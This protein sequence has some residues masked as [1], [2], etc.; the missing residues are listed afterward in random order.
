MGDKK[1]KGRESRNT[2]RWG[3][4]RNKEKGREKKQERDKRWKRG[5]KKKMEMEKVL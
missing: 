2:E 4:K 5:N 3:K 1:E